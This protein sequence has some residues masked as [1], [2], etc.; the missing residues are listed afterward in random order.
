MKLGVMETEIHQQS[1]AKRW[2]LLQLFILLAIVSVDR[3]RMNQ[4]LLSLPL[5]QLMRYGRTE[6]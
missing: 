4:F 5:K 2:Q 1:R 6:K 3:L